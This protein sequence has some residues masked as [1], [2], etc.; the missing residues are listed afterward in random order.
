MM[1]NLQCP[2]VVLLIAHERLASAQVSAALHG[3]HVARI[4][5]TSAL[6]A[7]AKGAAI[8]ARLAVQAACP[9]ETLTDV[10]EAAGLR[11]AIDRL[12]DLSR[13]ETIVVVTADDLIQ[14]LLGAA[15]VSGAPIALSIDADGWTML[16]P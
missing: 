14:D 3:R 15:N 8:L 2:A 4:F 5:V 6:S 9:L 16:R 1:S 12:A 7:D 13:G 11:Q 10:T